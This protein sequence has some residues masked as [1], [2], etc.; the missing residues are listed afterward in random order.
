MVFRYYSSAVSRATRG[1]A[2]TILVVGLLL[3]GFGSLIL[4]MPELFAI[5]AAA[6]FFFA[7]FSCSLTALKIFLAQRHADSGVDEGA[8]PPY[9]ENVRLHTRDVF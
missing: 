6:V 5:V 7:G 1:I 2:M 8:Y 9:R 4:A 3:I